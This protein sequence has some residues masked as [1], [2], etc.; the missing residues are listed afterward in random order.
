MTI[1]KSKGL[2]YDLVILL[3][4]N[5]TEWWSFG[6]DPGKGHSTLFM[7]ASR[8]KESL[9]MTRCGSDRSAKIGE[10][11]ALLDKAGVRQIR[12]S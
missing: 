7:A 10:I 1:T 3:G 8:A 12:T 2:E 4:S 11:V 5:D 6:R 9:I